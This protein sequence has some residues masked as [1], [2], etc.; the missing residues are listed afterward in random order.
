MLK[1]YIKNYLSIKISLPNHS[2]TGV[3]ISNAANPD[4]VAYNPIC[5]YIIPKLTISITWILNNTYAR[6][7]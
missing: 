2:C 7:T 6:C 1:S 3:K 5:Q 4:N